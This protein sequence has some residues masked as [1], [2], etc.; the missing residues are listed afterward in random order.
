MHLDC[1]RGTRARHPVA[2][3]WRA[4][5]PFSSFTYDKSHPGTRVHGAG[6]K[7]SGK[8]ISVNF[9]VVDYGITYRQM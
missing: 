6:G 7:P 9:E 4:S 1:L 5:S 3:N 8:P 2:K